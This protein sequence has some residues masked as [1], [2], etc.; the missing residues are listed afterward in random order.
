M[1]ASSTH[2]AAMRRYALAG[3]TLQPTLSAKGVVDRRALPE[4]I[5][6]REGTKRDLDLA[7]EMDRHLRGAPHGPDLE[8]LLDSGARMFVAKRDGGAGYALAREG[9]PLIVAATNEDVAA[10]LLWGVLST[11]DSQEE[12]EVG[13]L[14]A[15]QGWAV[16]VALAAGLAL[17]PAGPICIRGELGAL[18]PYLP[19]GAFL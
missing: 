7:A 19:N 14:T 12:V 5:P 16:R 15:E 8:F 13:W 6:V 2:P 3:F 18:A 10:D 1:I 11:S 9:R 4:K 17:E